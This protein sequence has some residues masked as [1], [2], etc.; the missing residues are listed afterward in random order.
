MC[1]ALR[2]S[3]K[4]AGKPDKQVSNHI[5]AICKVTAFTLFSFL[6]IAPKASHRQR[7]C[8]RQRTEA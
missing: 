6:R 4:N 3:F 5:A 1:S 8:R 2:L 7:T